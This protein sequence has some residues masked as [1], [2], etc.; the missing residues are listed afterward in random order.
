MPDGRRQ[1]VGNG[2][3]WYGA[4]GGVTDTRSFMLTGQTFVEG[5]LRVCCAR[6]RVFGDSDKP[7]DVYDALSVARTSTNNAISAIFL[8]WC[9]LI[10]VYLGGRSSKRARREAD[11]YR[12]VL[13]CR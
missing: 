9:V 2:M 5:R 13:L 4:H 3:R 7:F 1:A 12:Q 6:S 10:L 8:A 11:R